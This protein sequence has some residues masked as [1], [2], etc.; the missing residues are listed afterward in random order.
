MVFNQ[1]LATLFKKLKVGNDKKITPNSLGVIFFE[2]SLNARKIR[3][4]ITLFISV[5]MNS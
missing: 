3:R 1:T 2:H 5:Y 4:P